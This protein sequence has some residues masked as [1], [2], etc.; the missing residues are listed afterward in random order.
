MRAADL[1]ALAAARGVDLSRVG[2]TA[3]ETRGTAAPRKRTQREIWDGVDVVETSARGH[4]TRTYRRPAW[5]HAELGMGAKGIEEL[6]WCAALYSFAGDATVCRRLFK[7]LR[8]HAVRAADR[9]NWGEQVTGRLPRD[10][11]TAKVIPGAKAEPNFYLEELC[12]LLLDEEAAKFRFV[13]W[14]A[15]PEVHALYMNV[16]ELTWQRILE[17]RYRELQGVYEHWLGIARGMIQRWLNEDDLT[18]A[19]G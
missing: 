9:E 10:P 16:E 12:Q 4:G 3:S 6:P 7:A 1:V 15:I 17:P 5:S 19:E 14:R 2:G 8:R 13:G 18:S 11:R